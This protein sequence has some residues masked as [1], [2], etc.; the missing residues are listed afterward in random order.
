MAGERDEVSA[1]LELPGRVWAVAAVH[2]QAE[3]LRALHGA[4]SARFR[5]G[6]RLVYLGNLV[7]HGADAVAT[8]DEALTFRRF[9]LTTPG[10][11]PWDI[12]YL[13]G[14]Q[15]EMLAKLLQLHFARA[16]AEVLAWMLGQGVGPTLEA[17]GCDVE[18]VRRRCREGAVA[19]ARWTTGLIEAL[20]RHP[21]HRQLL[22]TLRRYAVT[23]DGS[24]LFV[25]AGIDPERP[26][27]E[28]GDTFWWGSGYFSRISAQVSGFRLV[29]RGYDRAG[30]G[31][32]LGLW[33]ATIDGGCGFGGP[34]IA[35][36]FGTD[37]TIVDW[38]ET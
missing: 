24:L 21:G 5:V 30:G 11:E 36:C 3:R 17:Y 8:I 26:L 6:D 10:A 12:A 33:R 14:G 34:L 9:L 28:Q 18:E 19:L 2:A 23:D 27:S 38:I 25:N 13:R 22:T 32:D 35:A 29:V 16:P 15:E 20:E 37:G 31:V 4:L 7:G 1:C